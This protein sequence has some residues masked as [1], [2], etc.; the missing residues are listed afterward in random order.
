MLF[1][2]SSAFNFP[3]A[4]VKRTRKC[5]TLSVRMMLCDPNDCCN[6]VIFL[7]S[8][9]ALFA[10]ECCDVAIQIFW[11]HGIQ[12]ILMISLFILRTKNKKELREKETDFFSLTRIF[13]LESARN[14]VRVPNVKLVKA[15]VS[16]IVQ[17]TTTKNV[18]W[19][20]G[21]IEM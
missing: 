10:H 14:N 19:L 16:D 11:F 20:F 8:T 15:F 3:F 2:C 5:W 9:V 6:T 21:S 7:L 4:W 12:Y 18:Y 13:F 17:L 1:V